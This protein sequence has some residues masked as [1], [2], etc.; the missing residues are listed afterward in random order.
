MDFYRV[1]GLTEKQ[2]DQSLSPAEVRQAYKQALLHHHPDKQNTAKPREDKTESDVAPTT[3]TVDEIT[4]AYQT[5]A[6]PEL[7]AAYDRQRQ[8]ADD[9]L[10]EHAPYP[11]YH[12]YVGLEVVDLEELDCHDESAIWT[13]SCRCGS[14]P[15]FIVTEAELEKNSKS[16]E[17]ITGCKGCSLCLKVLF[18]EAA[19]SG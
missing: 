16:G 4:K 12:C 15:A 11:T 8:G 6:D 1:L 2:H 7:R 14:Q 17:V 18:S 3:F 10:Q 9:G 19:S 13:R 5:L